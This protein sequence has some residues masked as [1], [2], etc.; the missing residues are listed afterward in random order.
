LK[1]SAHE[2]GTVVSPTHRLPL[3]H[4]KHSWFSFVLQSE[5]TPEQQSV[6]KDYVN[7]KFQ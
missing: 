4:R 7:E 3:P 6:R 1:Q 5:S 2:D